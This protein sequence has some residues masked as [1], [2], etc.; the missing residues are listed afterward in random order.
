MKI[1]KELDFKAVYLKLP[2]NSTEGEIFDCIDRLN[3][4][5]S[6]HGILVQVQLYV[7]AFF[8]QNFRIWVTFILISVTLRLCE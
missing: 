1:A 8:L 5:S 3:R 7:Y 4:D 2:S 6:I